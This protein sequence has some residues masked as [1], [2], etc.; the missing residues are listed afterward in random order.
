MEHGEQ[1]PR[2]VLPVR[3]FILNPFTTTRRRKKGARWWQCFTMPAAM[4]CQAMITPCATSKPCF[5]T[6]ATLAARQ[7]KIKQWRC[8]R[9]EREDTVS[10]GIAPC[11]HQHIE[12]MPAPSCEADGW[13][14]CAMFETFVDIYCVLYRQY[15]IF[16]YIW[17]ISYI[18]IYGIYLNIYMCVCQTY[19][20]GSYLHTI[21]ISNAYIYIYVLPA[22]SI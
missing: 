22:F 13:A 20:C 12:V 15:I 1:N 10:G 9:G 21:Y 16:I 14:I 6:L 4:R 18:Y 11:V 5:A 3:S 17:I 2:K 19:M 8:Q 7:P